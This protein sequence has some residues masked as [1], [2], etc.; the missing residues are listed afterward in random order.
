MVFIV[1]ILLVVFFIIYP[2]FVI[3][4]ILITIINNVLII[5]INFYEKAFLSLFVDSS[6][7]P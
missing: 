1:S 4:V 3:D 7:F 2:S 5:F 6:F